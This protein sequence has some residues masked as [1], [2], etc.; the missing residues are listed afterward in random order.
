MARDYTYDTKYQ[1]SPQQIKNRVIRNKA[2]RHAIKKNGA[3]A[4]K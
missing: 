3:A 4:M 1:S 2:R